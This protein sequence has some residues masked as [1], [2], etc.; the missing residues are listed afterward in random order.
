MAT[1]VFHELL[2]LMVQSEASDVHIK[3]GAPSVFRMG[4]S[5]TDTSYIPDADTMQAFLDQVATTEQRAE[6]R[7]HGDL[8]LS[9]YEDGIGRFRVNIHRQRS[10][11]SINMRWVK[12]TIHTFQELGL[13]ETLSKIARAERGIIFITGTTGVGKSTTLAA[14]LEYINANFR[15][16][17]ITIEDPIEYEFTDNLSLFEQREVGIDTSSFSSALTHALRQDPDIIMVGE[18]R[19][20]A[21]FDAALSAADTGH[22]VLSTVHATNAYQTI[23]RLLDFYKQEEQNNIRESLASNLHSIISQRL[24]SK[25]F[26]N[27]R[28]PAWEIMINTPVISNMIRENRINEIPAVIAGDKTDGMETFNQS[29][30]TL[31]NNGLISEEDALAASDSPEALQMNFNG[32]FLSSEKGGGIT[33]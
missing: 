6:Y 27:G 26:S 24:I 8:D 28:V 29:L 3:T 18:M 14:M 23:T 16:H 11:D 17:I 31:V 15:K 21:S 33:G 13:P 22:L 7:K 2:A 30:F 5:L 10:T 19:D 32:I 4:N 12:N 9:L 25:V 1:T 20:R